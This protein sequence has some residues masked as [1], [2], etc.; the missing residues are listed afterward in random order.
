MRWNPLLQLG[1][2]LALV[3]FGCAVEQYG[4]EKLGIYENI[5]LA[6]S[7][8]ESQDWLGIAGGKDQ[9]GRAL[10]ERVIELKEPAP[11]QASIGVYLRKQ[12]G[13][14]LPSVVVY[15]GSQRWADENKLVG[16]FRVK[17]WPRPDDKS[18]LARVGFEITEQ[19]ALLMWLGDP[20]PDR[21][22]LANRELLLPIPIEWVDKRT[23]KRVE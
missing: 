22:G 1:V 7:N 20:G 10:F 3:T 21:R 23:T 6:P 5:L 19:R 16:E 12:E 17:E 18:F 13:G 8:G 11:R 14:P 9:G 4:L 2:L 15:R